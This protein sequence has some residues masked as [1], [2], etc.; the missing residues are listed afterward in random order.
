M[1]CVIIMC[2]RTQ[3]WRL[4]TFHTYKTL[5][6]RLD[7]NAMVPLAKYGSFRMVPPAIRRGNSQL[8]ARIWGTTLSGLHDCLVLHC[9][10]IFLLGKVK[11][12]EWKGPTSFTSWSSGQGYCFPYKHNVEHEWFRTLCQQWLP[13]AKTWIQN[14]GNHVEGRAGQWYSVNFRMNM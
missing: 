6:G 4:S 11:S 8:T 9:W 5:H 14:Q 12:D 7:S 13:E 2:V 10:I 1:E 3:N